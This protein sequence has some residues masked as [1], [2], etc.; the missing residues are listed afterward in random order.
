MKTDEIAYPSQLTAAEEQWLHTKPFGTFNRAES[1]RN[2]HDVSTLLTLILKHAPKAE[3]II[4]LGCG[5]GWLSL[6]LAQLG[7]DVRG[8]D[9][10]PEM[11]A[12]AKD[13]ARALSPGPQFAVHDMDSPL[14]LPAGEHAD[15]VIIYDAL[16]HC[17]EDRPVLTNAYASLR[18]HGILILAEPNRAHATDADSL[19]AVKR[20]GVTERGL[21]ARTLAR[22]CRA[23][24]FTK[25]WRYH[26]S[27][28]SF[29]PRH[30]GFGET[31]KMLAYPFLARFIY[32]N[33]RTRIWLV[34]EK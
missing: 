16:H 1:Q 23:V 17:A 10:S 34:A 30:E 25:T 5:P 32:G 27:G 8:Y 20:F 22:E 4:E 14:A 7:Y 18:P 29:Q 11:I 26:A 28:Q 6:I 12:V 33:V 13:R 21:D 31:I 2:L 9:L 15:V 3:R 19:E 24:G